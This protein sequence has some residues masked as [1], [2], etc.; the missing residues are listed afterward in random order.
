M[1]LESVELILEVEKRFCISLPDK[2]LSEVKTLS[3]FSYII[4]QECL[5]N[6]QSITDSEVFNRLKEIIH[7]LF[8]INEE[9]ILPSSRIIEDLAID[10]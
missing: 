2:L 10:Q 3:Q 6:Q 4:W 7:E 8:N 9:F 1:G 5:Q